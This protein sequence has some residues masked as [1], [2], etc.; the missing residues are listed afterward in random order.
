MNISDFIKI[1]SEHWQHERSNTQ[2][3]LG[4]LITI[5]EAMPENSIVANLHDAHSFRG[6]YCDLAFEHSEGTRPAKELLADCRMALGAA[7]SGYKGGDYIMKERTPVWIADYGC[8]GERLIALD[9]N[10]II[11]EEEKISDWYV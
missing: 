1:M 8:S 7:F 9:G 6:Y 4:E 10:N 3:T 11:T 2:M 5:L